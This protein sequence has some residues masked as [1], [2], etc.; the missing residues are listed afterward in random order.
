MAI[1]FDA[2]FRWMGLSVDFAIYYRHTEF[3]SNGRL[4]SRQAIRNKGGI[5]NLTD[6]G[7]TFEVAYFIIA[8]KLNVALRYSNLDADD[9]WQGGA[10]GFSVRPDATDIGVAVTYY[11][12]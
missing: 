9:F 10:S 7:W 8:Q 2:H 6:M 12:Q 1:T 11:V 3:H 4:S 5:A